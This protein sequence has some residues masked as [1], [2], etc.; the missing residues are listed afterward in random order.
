M[1]GNWKQSKNEYCCLLKY[2]TD[3]NGVIHSKTWWPL[4]RDNVTQ[5]V[6]MS[7]N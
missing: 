5:R 6:N 1:R 2:K 7:M 4:L 3:F